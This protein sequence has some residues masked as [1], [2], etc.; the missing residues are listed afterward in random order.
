LP[1]NRQQDE[2]PL[3]RQLSV[4]GIWLLAVNGMIGAGI[5]GVPAGAAERAQYPP[6][7]TFSRHTYGA[8]AAAPA[9][10]PH[11]R[12][13]MAGAGRVRSAHGAAA[14]P[15]ELRHRGTAGD[16]RFRRWESAV[17]PAG[18]TRNPARDMPRA[19]ILAMAVVTML[20]VLVQAVA[21]AVLP[22]LAASERALVDVGAV[23]FGPAGA[24]LLTAAVVASVGGNLAGTMVTVPRLTYALARE[25]SLP[26]C[27]ARPSPG[28]NARQFHPFFRGAGADP[29]GLR[30]VC[31]AGG[32]ERTGAGPD[33][34]GVHRRAAFLVDAPVPR[35]RYAQAKP[36][37]IRRPLATGSVEKWP[38][39][40]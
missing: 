1:G 29:R 24:V 11:R 7:H 16:L 25:E 40:L 10:D 6:R 15:C 3:I 13:R 38:C 12:A 18:E 27:R 36:V 28:A 33:L 39:M 30:L 8:E 37:I 31:L 9:C 20:Y 19:L 22:D 2:E 26:A 5:F 35:V 17:V 21:V 32:H 23:L 34:H 4:A 14:R